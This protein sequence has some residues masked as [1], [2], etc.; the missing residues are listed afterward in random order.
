LKPGVKL[1]KNG[2]EHAMVKPLERVYEQGQWRHMKASMPKF[3]VR[4]HR[5]GYLAEFLWNYN[6]VLSTGLIM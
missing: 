4:K 3:G 2:Y 6:W 1:E 5:S